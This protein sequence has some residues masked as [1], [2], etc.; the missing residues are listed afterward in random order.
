MPFGLIPFSHPGARQT[1][2]NTIADALDTQEQDDAAAL[3]ASGDRLQASGAGS[4][5]AD[6][7]NYQATLA[8]DQADYDESDATA[9][10]SLAYEENEAAFVDATAVD[11]ANE[12]RDIT[13]AGDQETEQDAEAQATDTR[14]DGQADND[15]NKAQADA[16]SWQGWEDGQAGGN[17]TFD[18][19]VIAAEQTFHDTLAADAKTANDAAA[20]NQHIGPSTPGDAATGN[21]I[22]TAWTDS[23]ATANNTYVDAQDS[24]NVSRDGDL[25]GVEETYTDSL[26]GNLNTWYAQNDTL[27]GRD[28]KAVGAALA[29]QDEDDTAARDTADETAA[30]LAQTE[31]DTDAADEQT[32][33]DN[34]AVEQETQD[35]ADSEGQQT[36]EETE[37]DDYVSALAAWV[38]SLTPN[39]QSPTPLAASAAEQY[40]QAQADD[41]WVYSETAAQVTDV[42]AEDAAQVTWA[43]SVDQ[44]SEAQTTADA[45]A[46]AAA[47]VSSDEADA[48]RAATDDAA[49]TTEAQN[50][51]GATTTYDQADAEANAVQTTSDAAAL[52]TARDA[53]DTALG[54]Y[55]DAQADAMLAVTL[56]GSDAGVG[57][58]MAAAA[59]AQYQAEAAASV[60][61]ANTTAGDE[62]TLMKS[63]ADAKGGDSPS[64][65]GESEADEGGSGAGWVAGMVDAEAGYVSSAATAGAV[66]TQSDAQ[67]AATMDETL[68]DDEGNFQISLGDDGDTLDATDGTDEETLI[69][70]EDECD[71]ADEVGYAQANATYQNTLW[72]AYA[73]QL[74]S[75]IPNPQSPTPESVLDQ[76]YANVALH[77]SQE[78]STDGTDLV[79][80][81]ESVTQ[82][83]VALG[84]EEETASVDQTAADDAAQQSLTTTLVPQEEAAVDD[85]D[86]VLVQAAT[87][88]SDAQAAYETTTADA[89]A[90]FYIDKGA[91]S[92]VYDYAAAD[93]GKAMEGAMAQPI[94]D[95]SVEILDGETPTVDIGADAA[96][97][98]ATYNTA[99]SGA[100]VA[101]ITSYGTAEVTEATSIGDAQ[102]ALAT[103]QGDDEVTLTQNETQVSDTLE[104]ETLADDDTLN[105]TLTSDGETNDETGAQDESDTTTTEGSDEV[106][107]QQS[108]ANE[109]A[110]TAAN[111]AGDQANYAIAMAQ[112]AAG[113]AASYAQA[114]PSNGQAQFASLY[115]QGYVTWLTD[116]SSA[117]VTNATA[118]ATAAGGDEV[119]LVT[120]DVNLADLEAADNVTNVDTEDP[121]SAQESQGNQATD[122]TYQQESVDNI[123]TD[124]VSSA[125]ADQTQMLDLAEAASTYIVASAQADKTCAINGF[126]DASDTSQ[127]Y[128]TAVAD[129]K[130]ALADSQADADQAWIADK[131]DADETYLT[132]DAEDWQ[133]MS[134]DEAQT[135]DQYALTGDG[136][137]QTADDTQASQES[138]TLTA[139]ATADQTQGNADASAEAAFQIAQANETSTVWNDIVSSATSAGM[140]GLPWMQVQAGIAGA[141]ATW[142]V[143]AAANYQTYVAALGTAEVAYATSDASQFDTE[144][145]TIDAADKTA[146]DDAANTD[147]TLS[148]T[149]TDDEATFEETLASAG[150][151]YQIAV[152]EAGQNYRQATAQADHDLT[153]ET[154]DGDPNAETDYNNEMQAAE[155]AKTAAIDQAYSD[156]AEAV[157]PAMTLQGT[158]DANAQETDTETNATGNF[159][160]IEGNNSAVDIYDDQ[161]SADYATQQIADATAL[162]VMQEANANGNAAAIASYDQ[163]NPSPWADMANW[164]AAAQATQQV[165]NAI[166][167]LT[168][169]ASEATAQ[170][171]DEQSQSDATTAKDDAQADAEE[172][173]T[174]TQAEADDAEAVAQ[175]AATDAVFTYLPDILIAPTDGPTPVLTPDYLW[176]YEANE[177][178]VGQTNG[179][180]LQASVEMG[181]GWVWFR[182]APTFGGPGTSGPYIGDFWTPYAA[183]LSSYLGDA[184]GEWSQLDNATADLTGQS[185]ATGVSGGM[186]Y[187]NPIVFTPQDMVRNLLPEAE[188][189][190]P[191]MHFTGSSAELLDLINTPSNTGPGGYAQSPLPTTPTSTQLANPAPSKNAGA[192][193]EDV[194]AQSGADAKEEGQQPATQQT[195]TATAAASGATSAVTNGGGFLILIASVVLTRDSAEE[196]AVIN[197]ESEGEPEIQTDQMQKKLASADKS[198][199]RAVYGPP[200][201]GFAGSGSSSKTGGTSGSADGSNSDT[202]N[203]GSEN[204]APTTIVVIEVPAQALAAPPLFEDIRDTE[205]P[206]GGYTRAGPS[207]L[208]TVTPGRDVAGTGPGPWSAPWWGAY[209]GV[210][211]IGQQISKLVRPLGLPVDWESR[212]RA[213]E[214]NFEA[215]GL[216]GTKAE[217]I[218]KFS[219]AN[220]GK[221]IEAIFIVTTVEAGLPVVGRVAGSALSK[222]PGGAAA[223]EAITEATPGAVKFVKGPWVQLPL[224]G[225]LGYVT[226]LEGSASY[227]FAK[228]GD[229]Q[230]AIDHGSNAVIVLAFAAESTAQGVKGAAAAIDR[231]IHRFS[232]VN[233][234][235]VP[236]NPS[237]AALI[238]NIYGEGEAAGFSDFATEG[239]FANGRPLTSNLS[240]GAASDIALRDAP[241]SRTTLSEM[242]RLA[243]SKARITVANADVEGFQGYAGQLRGAF[244]QAIVVHE[245][246]AV[247]ADGVERGVIVIQLRGE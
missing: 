147:L 200:A 15:F 21:A 6:W 203:S 161:E 168:R 136:E 170:E 95:Y 159:T 48:Q 180:F 38:Q 124:E 109:E 27:L 230:S 132:A 8:I 201:N 94:A 190:A 221:A 103:A 141:E 155:D 144:L 209:V 216:K 78:I 225:T 112:I 88:D 110:T 137:T 188:N 153:V 181:I 149:L 244:P 125:Q 199:E 73:T 210:Q 208:Y 42:E 202:T 239:R 25:T 169:S 238:I 50:L 172:T 160:D 193:L 62:A 218:T 233:S 7:D 217:V 65:Q 45:A 44:Q 151:A 220:A 129:A 12:T 246:I 53:W 186:T 47:I 41:E 71:A 215:L 115:A 176:G 134:D 9:Q 36:F 192:S 140:A 1:R 162:S 127:V 222:V 119:A 72:S 33:N 46:M 247:G 18:L 241:L 179:V 123:G 111:L 156:F 82:A 204:P 86:A 126:N 211:V 150:A 28:E 66:E 49:W 99:M 146:A 87:A 97:A 138:A 26:S 34:E 242:R 182:G 98:D 56:S 117:F 226:Y 93:A 89:I 104:T 54:A 152:G 120:S 142:A 227:D 84:D 164:Q 55:L 206:S 102:V 212:D 29:T 17:Q 83:D 19:A 51:A 43:D 11:Q 2:D 228:A 81:V 173:Q 13:I 171:S 189:F 245:G 108:L 163:A 52:K 74:Q 165:S 232:V 24:D 177:Y 184:P 143:T 20:S 130:L 174:D 3:Q 236:V 64:L 167:T 187:G 16:V 60:T 100:R 63:L 91:A 229:T 75:L 121:Q 90:R 145:T 68:A 10:D 14:L 79:D 157:E 213:V 234:D 61:W 107:T 224:G 5:E 194:P 185:A 105:N 195:E 35:V 77:Q 22:M 243:A 76:Y 30:N 131:A 70:A 166:A 59:L 32:Y 139:E 40:Q 135:S 106:T 57:A 69:H 198:A 191:P 196:Q 183:Q 101:E 178:Y 122:D 133:T 92:R 219:G 158:D 235:G 114:N 205:A 80:E 214:H 231:A 128:E 116:L 148:T 23:D 67:T 207:Y 39:P 118:V 240:D 154:I 31:V 237:G 37:A 4:S 223:V 85:A 175:A 96:A 58:A 197:D 113:T